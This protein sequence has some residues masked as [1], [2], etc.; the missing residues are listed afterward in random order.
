MIPVRYSA[1][2]PPDCLGWHRKRL[3]W[4]LSLECQS[5]KEPKEKKK[6]ERDR[7][8]DRDRIPEL[9]SYAREKKHTSASRL[10]R[11]EKEK[12]RWGCP[13]NVDANQRRVS[14]VEVKAGG[15]RCNAR[16]VSPFRSDGVARRGCAGRDLAA[17]DAIPQPQRSGRGGG[18]IRAGHCCS[19]PCRSPPKASARAVQSGSVG[20]A[21][22]VAA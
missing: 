5:P 3:V 16:C 19:P 13:L 22:P 8:R 11:K 4:Y 20:P 21:P 6:K 17:K 2:E 18:P 12:K 9:P 1:N 15:R 7:D 14:G 10:Q